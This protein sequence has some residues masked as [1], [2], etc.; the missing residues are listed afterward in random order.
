MT[1]TLNIIF[2]NFGVCRIEFRLVTALS[3]M[4][5]NKSSLNDYTGKSFVFVY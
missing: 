2:D 5:L 3:Q 1:D 4:Y